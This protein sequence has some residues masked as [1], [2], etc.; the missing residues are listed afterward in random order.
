MITRIFFIRHGEVDNPK[1]V[2][3]GRLPGFSL[4]EKG[5]K[6]ILQASQFL[7]RNKIN[8]L[9][10]SPL[11]RTKQSAEI[12]SR[13][14]NL[15]INYSDDLLEIKSSFQGRPNNYIASRTIKF[16]IFTDETIEDVN[17]RMQKFIDEIIS[18]YKGRN[19]AAVTHGDPIMIVKAKIKGLPMEIN[20]I[21]PI[22]GYI[23]TGEAYIAE[24]NS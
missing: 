24:F 19:I 22:K 16:N 1:K 13:I 7:L 6:Q 8:A 14:L 21:R 3:Y 4:S 17:G 11:L 15:P 5:E 10:A 9:Y 23:K 18:R 12:I 20:S 2:W